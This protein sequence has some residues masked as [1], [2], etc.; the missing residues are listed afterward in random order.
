MRLSRLLF[1]TIPRTSVQTTCRLGKF[2]FFNDIYYVDCQL[3]T[4]LCLDIVF[5]MLF[6]VSVKPQIVEFVSY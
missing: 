2:V 1:V 4:I 5:G 6:I 3:D